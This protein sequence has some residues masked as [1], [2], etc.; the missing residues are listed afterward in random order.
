MR[1]VTALEL[2]F[3]EVLTLVSALELGLTEVPMIED[4]V[5]PVPTR[6]YEVPVAEGVLSTEVTLLEETKVVLEDSLEVVLTEVVLTEVLA[7]A[8]VDGC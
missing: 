3:S 5:D 7:L 8:V 1:L 4:L 2:G 6:V